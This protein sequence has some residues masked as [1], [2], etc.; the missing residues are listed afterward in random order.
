MTEFV[1]GLVPVYDNPLTLPNVVATLREIVDHVI[2]IDDGSNRET[3]Q[4]VDDL[5]SQDA[6]HIHVQHLAHNSGKGAAVKIGLQKALYLG[7]SHALQV[8]ADGQHDLRDI[9]KLL[10]SMRNRPNALILGSPVFGH[11]APVIRR[12]GRKMTTLMVALEAGTW[13][14]P[15]TMCGFRIYPVAAT[16]AI[17]TICSRMCFDPEIVI[18]SHWA[19]IPI[20]YVTTQVRYLPQEEGGVSH[21]RLLHDNLLQIGLHVCLL[22]QAPFRWIM[23]YFKVRRND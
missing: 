22:L 4:L 6:A 20:E 23:R 10:A 1:C 14:L 21:Y 17:H 3:R 19:G 9:P 8:D 11:D 5:A 12:Y 2:I 18:R 15:D 16:V 7:F 13:L